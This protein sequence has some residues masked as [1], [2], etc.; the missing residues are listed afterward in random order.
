[1]LVPENLN[2]A[3]VILSDYKDFQEGINQVE[4]YFQRNLPVL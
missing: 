1:M 2:I 4:A 3:A